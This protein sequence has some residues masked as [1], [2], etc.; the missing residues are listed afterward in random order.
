MLVLEYMN[1]GSLQSCVERC[2]PLAPR[3]VRH[4]AK[5]MFAGLAALHERHLVHRDI[6]PGNVLVSQRGRIKLTDF[7]ISETVKTSAPYLDGFVGTQIYMSP[8]RLEGAVYGMSADIW[9]AGLV[10]AFAALGRHPYNGHD[11]FFGIIQD[12]QTRP[13]PELP[14]PFGAD[15]RHL[16]DCCLQLNP[17]D[18]WTAE[19]LLHHPAFKG[20]DVNDDLDWVLGAELQEDVYHRELIASVLASKVAIGKK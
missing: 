10:V 5:Q 15:F 11:G 18:R 14:E 6:K 9:A 3:V 20:V 1:R 8:E 13:I 17:S 12:I 7:G 4:F 16:L 2:G 19:Q